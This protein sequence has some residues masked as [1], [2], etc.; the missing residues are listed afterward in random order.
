MR[1]SIE[2]IRRRY[3]RMRIGIWHMGI[4]VRSANNSRTEDKS[5]H[6]DDKEIQSNDQR[7]RRFDRES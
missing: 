3:G 6:H 4:Q 1:M 2:S 7:G 5:V